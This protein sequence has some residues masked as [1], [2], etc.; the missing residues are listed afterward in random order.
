M[1]TPGTK[2]WQSAA[3]AVAR[4]VPRGALH[5]AVVAWADGRPATEKWAVALSG[6]S[7]SVALIM[8]LWALW[9]KRRARL[10]AYHFNHR[11]RGN[12]SDADERFCRALCKALGVPLV[13]A[14]WKAA[15]GQVSE[16]AAR[17][18]RFAFLEPSL[19]RQ[20]TR[21]LWLGH[22]QDDIAETM[23][24]RLSRGSGAAGL[25]APRPVHAM[26]LGG[27]GMT[28]VRPLLTLKK[29]EIAAALKASK[30][31]WREDSSNAK[32]VHFRNRVR[33]DVLPVWVEASQRDAVAGA[34]LSR[35]LL[36]EDN[37][38]LEAWVASLGLFAPDGSMDVG[39]L[40]GRPTAIVRRALHQWLLAQD[41]AGDFSRQAFS[42][43]LRSV[44]L[45]SPIRHSLGTHGFAVIRKGRLRFERGRKPR[46]LH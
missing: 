46:S 41:K 18:A 31:P 30:A 28:H 8:I 12:A 17:S 11:L 9:P 36:E 44:K 35:E 19:A 16:S 33:S 38:A 27:K 14:R 4:L 2:R 40:N 24:M 10:K 1:K 29:A 23:L 6:G 34:A 3:D 22:Q 13:T 5:P 7:D 37:H 42:V 21:V 20:R 25:A 45:G 43:L 26:G 39:K 32:G 15:R